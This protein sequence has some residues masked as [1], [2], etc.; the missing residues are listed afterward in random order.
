MVRQA[1]HPEPGRR[2][3]LKC[4]YSNDQIAIVISNLG[5]CNLFVV[6]DLF[7]GIYID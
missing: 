5:D 3:N 1:H 7:F 4:Q 2:V 6:C